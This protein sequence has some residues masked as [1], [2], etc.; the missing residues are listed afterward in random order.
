MSK[1]KQELA[2]QGENQIDEM[3]LF[4][5]VSAIIENRKT[6]A[7][8]YAKNILMTLSTKLSWSHFCKITWVKTDEG[9]FSTPTMQLS[10]KRS[11]FVPKDTPKPPDGRRNNGRKPARNSQE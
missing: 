3:V 9:R 2:V 10:V 6:R 11:W 7:G 5:R 4:R 1:K 8:A